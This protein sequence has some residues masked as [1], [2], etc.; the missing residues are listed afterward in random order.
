MAQILSEPIKACGEPKIFFAGEA[1]SEFHF[2]TVHGA[3]ETGQKQAQKIIE[4]L[5]N[6]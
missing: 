3:Y 1:I 4:F 2:S 5:R 6:C